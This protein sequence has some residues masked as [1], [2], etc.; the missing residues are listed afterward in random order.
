MAILRRQRHEIPALNTSSLPDLIFT[1]LFF[2]MIVTHMCKTDVKVRYQ[3][4]QGT[5]LS[6]L[7][8][9]RNIIYLYLG[10]PLN[11]SSSSDDD[12][13]LQLD[14][15]IVRLE[16]LSAAV[17]ERL[18][19]FNE[20]D[21]DQVIV[22]IKAD[23]RIPMKTINAVKEALRKAGALKVNYSALKFVS[24]ENGKK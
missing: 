17:S 8:Q 21:R 5:E 9:K 4:P 24:I 7:L 19:Q 2:F 6:T 12:V 14:E 20:A 13:A 22:S 1:V 11:V 3:E 10:Q 15:R 23:K 16:S 18:S